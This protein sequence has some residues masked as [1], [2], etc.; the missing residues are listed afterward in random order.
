MNISNRAVLHY[1]V[2][3]RVR[4]GTGTGQGTEE[5]KREAARTEQIS[6]VL[7]GVLQKSLLGPV[8]HKMLRVS[9]ACYFH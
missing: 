3:E 1:T 6:T 2:R 7:I 9:S 4:L 5:M 8:G